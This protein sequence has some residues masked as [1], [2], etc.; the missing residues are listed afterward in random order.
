[1]R[2]KNLCLL[3]TNSSIYLLLACYNLVAHPVGSYTILVKDG[4]ILFASPIFQAQTWIVWSSTEE[5]ITKIV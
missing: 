5:A 4:L 2:A 1:M 3:P